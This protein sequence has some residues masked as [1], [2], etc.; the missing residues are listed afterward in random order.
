MCG[1]NLGCL[2]SLLSFVVFCLFVFF[3]FLLCCLFVLFCFLLF[4]LFGCLFI[5]LFVC[6][7]FSDEKQFTGVFLFAR[8]L[9]GGMPPRWAH[10]QY[11]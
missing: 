4:C 3:C 8:Y 1:E 2:S 6:L 9:C 10:I 11:A 7:P 5:Y